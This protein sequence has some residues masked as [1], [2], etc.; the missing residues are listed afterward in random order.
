VYAAT[1][2]RI[3]HLTVQIIEQEIVISTVLKGGLHPQTVRE[4]HNG[5]PKDIY[6]YLI[7]L[8]KQKHW[9]DEEILSKTVRI[10]VKYD[11][12]KKQYTVVRREWLDQS[13]QIDPTNLNLS[14]QVVS[15]FS[16]L[17]QA[18]SRIDEIR[19]APTHWLQKG[20]QYY[21][22]VKAQMKTV[23]LPL[24]FHYLLFFIPVLEL[25]TPWAYTPIP[26][27]PDRAVK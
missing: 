14:E 2:A 21:I 10:T 23:K 9:F 13:G 27:I 16:I 1:D 26:S 17:Q 6:Y 24:Y 8:R 3:D 11:T 15:D 4:I 18:V 12:L 5:I 20:S 22:G 7:L 25:D 19:I